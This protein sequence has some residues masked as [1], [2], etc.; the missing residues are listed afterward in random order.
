MLMDSGLLLV[1]IICATA[2]GYTIYLAYQTITARNNTKCGG[3]CNCGCSECNLEEKPFITKKN[4][5][6]EEKNK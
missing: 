6:K 4:T 1:L 2:I 3:I 5:N